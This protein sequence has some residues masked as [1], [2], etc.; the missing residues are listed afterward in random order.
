MAT[1]I[2]N[3]EDI[4]LR[5]LRVLKE[6]RL[7]AAEDT[8]HT[9]KL[10]THYQIA[11]PSTS[12]HEH[13]KGEKLGYLLEKLAQG[14]VAL[15][16]DAGTPGM[17]DPGFELIAAAIRQNVAVVPIPGP[18]VVITALVVSGMPLYPSLFVG[19][20]PNRAG[21]RRRELEKIQAF[22]GTIIALEAP[23]RLPAALKDLLA[24]LGD[25][26]VAV[27]RE[28]TKVH[29]E[30]F[31][32]SLSRAIAHFKAPKGEI[33]LVIAGSPPKAPPQMTDEIKNRLAGMHAAGEKAKNAVSALAGETGLGR[34]EL[35]Q[36]WLEITGQIK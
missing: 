13:N 36:A 22:E 3:L 4:S 6:V 28:L 25:R 5:A 33:T 1:P 8:R 32:G 9:R 11:T 27:C 14:D 34:R 24:T 15:V 21:A 17:S 16:S 26:Q 23:H 35:Y 18:A 10:L 30:V 12:Y 29:E 2:G 7:I 31:R 19:F 20:L